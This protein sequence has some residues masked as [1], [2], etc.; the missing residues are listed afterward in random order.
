MQKL[1]LTD[2][3]ILDDIAGFKD[4]ILAA[5]AKLED[6]PA[7]KLPYKEH[8]KREKARKV[9]EADIDH[10]QRLIEIAEEALSLEYYLKRASNIDE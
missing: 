10:V 5:Q 7:G 8:Q 1:N 3:E 4:R 9:Y 2:Q 6:L